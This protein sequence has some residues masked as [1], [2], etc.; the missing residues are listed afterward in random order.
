MQ[1]NPRSHALRGNA[2]LRRS[3]SKELLTNAFPCTC[4]ITDAER[5]NCPLPRGAWERGLCSSPVASISGLLEY[6]GRRLLTPI[7]SR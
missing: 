4:G 5:P 7:E 2:M 3:A 1:K 6:C